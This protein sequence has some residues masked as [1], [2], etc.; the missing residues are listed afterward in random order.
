M[1]DANDNKGARRIALDG[2]L[3]IYRAAEMKDKLAPHL[4]ANDRLEISLAGVT[5]ID[6]SGV[7]LLLLAK[8][9]LGARGI[10]VELT[11]HSPAVVEAIDLYG[12]SARFGDP[13]LISK[14]A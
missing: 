11:D 9:E 12:L 3:T 10:A 4:A 13:V 6:T 7:Q 2:E 5:E 8:R 14:Q 1:H